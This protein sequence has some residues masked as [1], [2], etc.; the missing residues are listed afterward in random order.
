[1]ESRNRINYHGN[2]LTETHGS[3]FEMSTAPAVHGEWLS[4]SASRDVQAV[5][6]ALAIASDSKLWDSLGL[7]WAASMSCSAHTQAI[8]G[9]HEIRNQA[10]HK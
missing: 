1:M 5:L 10:L 4:A 6:T 8:L 3:L 2:E 7:A 9:S